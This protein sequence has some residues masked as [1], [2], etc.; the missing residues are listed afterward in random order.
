MIT[1]ADAGAP[2]GRRYYEKAST[3]SDLS[4]EAIKALVEYGTAC[5]SPP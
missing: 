2:A 5:A 3:L 4:D 1:Q